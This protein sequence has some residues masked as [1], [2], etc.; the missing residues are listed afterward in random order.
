MQQNLVEIAYVALLGH[1]HDSVWV[2]GGQVLD[3]RKCLTGTLNE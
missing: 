3:E 1:T 2:A